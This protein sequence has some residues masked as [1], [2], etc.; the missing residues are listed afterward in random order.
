MEVKKQNYSLLITNYSLKLWQFAEKLAGFTSQ[1][2]FLADL[3]PHQ[4]CRTFLPE[5][6]DETTTYQE[7]LKAITT[8]E[9]TYVE[10]RGTYQERTIRQILI[11]QAE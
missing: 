10:K 4:G 3:C 9:R 1:H 7:G 6:G 8:F 11:K 2:F 5:G